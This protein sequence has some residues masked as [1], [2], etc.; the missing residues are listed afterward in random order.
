MNF[1]SDPKWYAIHTRASQEDLVAFNLGRMKLEV[2]NPKLKQEKFVWGRPQVIVKSLFPGYLFARFNPTKYL[3]LI[4]YSRGVRQVLRCGTALL[5]VD[6]EII[7]SIR[8]RIGSDGYVS[9][10]QERLVVGS[11]VSIQDGALSGLKGVFERE[12]RDRKRVVILLDAMQA[13]ARVVID[14]CVL[15]PV[16]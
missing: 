13:S 6:E 7:Q 2:L 5:P 15:K 3:H 8:A 4:H 14:R 12:T 1:D 9:L 16:A 11:K 10:Q